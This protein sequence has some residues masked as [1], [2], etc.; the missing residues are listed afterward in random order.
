MVDKTIGETHY[1]VIRGVRSPRCWIPL[2][3][4]LSIARGDPVELY[5][6][7]G[8]TGKVVHRQFDSLYDVYTQY[9]FLEVNRK[10]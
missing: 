10:K 1:L 5:M 7:D 2:L 3:G 6:T 9:E 4:L 8:R